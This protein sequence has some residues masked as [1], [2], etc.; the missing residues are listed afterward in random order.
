MTTDGEI[1]EIIAEFRQT[2]RTGV[3]RTPSKRSRYFV[4]GQRV[5]RAAFLKSSETVGEL[6]RM[7]LT[8][9]IRDSGK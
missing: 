5:T 2:K 1:D 8:S 6:R 3:L 7:E 4:K 9:V